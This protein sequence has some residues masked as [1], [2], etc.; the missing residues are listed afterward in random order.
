MTGLRYAVLVALVGCAPAFTTVPNDD[1]QALAPAR[2][3]A[4]DNAYNTQLA[5]LQHA[6][7]AANAAAAAV[8][9]VR[10][11]VVKG[12]NVAPG[13]AWADAMKRY[14]H[15]RTQ[16]REQIDTMTFEWQQA[17]IHYQLARVTLID[18]QLDELRAQHELDRAMA[19]DRSLDVGDT[20]DTA[21]YRGQLAA[22]QDPRFAAEH[23]VDTAR[24]E[25]Q[26]AAGKMTEAKET[27]ASIV[28][29]GPLAPT[30]ADS[31]YRLAAFAPTTR[32]AASRQ[33]KQYLT[34]PAARRIAGR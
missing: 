12:T 8:P 4:V 30:S 5:Q 7:S 15:D 26:R 29:G 21:G 28:R 34:E 23:R 13:D 17:V 10:L 27:Y 14:E 24:V 3:A 2:R 16:A 11:A 19:I 22:F 20:Y 9:K 25:L 6:L 31:S 33:P 32:Y 1:W 18:R